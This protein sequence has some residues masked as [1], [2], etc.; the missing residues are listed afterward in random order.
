MAKYRSVNGVWDR[1]RERFIKN[2][3]PEQ[4]GW[5]YLH[6]I[7]QYLLDLASKDGITPKPLLQEVPDELDLIGMKNLMD[8]LEY[9]IFGE[10]GKD[11]LLIL[12]E[13][14]LPI[15]LT[16]SPHSFIEKSIRELGGDCE[17]EFS[18]WRK[19]SQHIES[20]FDKDDYDPNPG[21]PLVYHLLGVDRY[22]DSLVLT[23]DDYL[24]FLIEITKADQPSSTDR[25]AQAIAQSS[26]LFLGFNLHSWEFRVLFHGL[27]K[28]S[29]ML[30][31]GKFIV[32]IDPNQQD[33]IP[34]EEEQEYLRSYLEDEAKLEIEWG[35]IHQYL[36]DLKV[37][38]DQAKKYA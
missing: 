28:P 13:M 4:L 22:E 16:T 27:I 23:E 24:T 19:G 15:Y 21:R 36:H 17:S 1:N 25:V 2:P 10:E 6:T 11:P 33:Q 12:A 7:K 26:L 5:E 29:A 38:S 8:L 30:K 9:P 35:E 18:R 37:L 34:T 14:S 31:E 3:S 32:Q 20:A